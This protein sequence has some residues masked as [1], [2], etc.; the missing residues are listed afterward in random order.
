VPWASSAE[1]NRREC[2]AVNNSGEELN[3]C[4][5]RAA[6]FAVT[7][8]AMFAKLAFSADAS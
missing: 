1:M 7:V 5:P 3:I 6:V 4:D 2:T 8:V